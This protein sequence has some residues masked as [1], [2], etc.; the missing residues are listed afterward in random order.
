[1]KKILLIRFSSIG[2]IVLTTP[3]IRAVRQQ[4]NYNI[5]A[6]TKTAYAGIYQSNPNI[7]RVHHFEKSVRE[8]LDE[9]QHENFDLII[10]LQKNLRSHRLIRKLALPHVSFPKLNKEKWLLVNFKINRLPR[11]HIV[12][13]YFEAVQ[14]MGVQNDGLGL[15]YYIP[16][17]AQ[18]NV[19]TISPVLLR[20]YAVFAIGGQHMTKIMPAHKIGAI[21]SGISVPILLLGSKADWES[22]NNMMQHTSNKNIWNLCGAYSLDESASLVMQSSLVL[23][24]DTGLMH[25]AAAFRKPIISIWGNTVPEFGMVPYMPQ[26][27]QRYI[28]S[29]VK[30]LAC[31][32]C[33]K[34][35]YRK[36]PKK[37][38][39][40]ML[41]QDE[42]FIIEKAHQ[43]ITLK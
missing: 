12:D 25:I 24:H 36:C 28:I 21:L 1:M 43:L 17:H 23:T 3:V 31:R 15:E 29:E 2:D 9:L 5:H 42:S 7:D 34:L 11:V 14:K 10:D 20:P 38:F 16:E 26:D 4:T 6:L 18:L 22:G 33:S 35:G 32:P 13:R 8:V 37:H 40:C 41:Q 19:S 39:N 30:G 27:E